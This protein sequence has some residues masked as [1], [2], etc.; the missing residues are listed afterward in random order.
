M[1]MSPRWTIEIL[2][3][4]EGRMILEGTASFDANPEITD[5]DVYAAVVA[6]CV[7]RTDAWGRRKMAK[8]HDGYDRRRTTITLSNGKRSRSVS[9][10]DDAMGMKDEE[11]ERCANQVMAWLLADE[12]TDLLTAS[13]SGFH[14]R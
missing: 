10:N 3:F 4:A 2:W 13:P 9:V 1:S 6:Q 7:M 11:A 12:T 8:H 14:R 5:P